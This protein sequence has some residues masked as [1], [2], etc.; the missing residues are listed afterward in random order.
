MAAQLDPCLSED[1]ADSADGL[2]DEDPASTV[3]EHQQLL[4]QAV[5]AGRVAA[6][7]CGLL[8]HIVPVQLLGG[9]ANRSLLFR[10]V[11][12]SSVLPV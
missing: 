3:N 4:Q 8:Q 11:R 7:V 9:K 6:F 2:P 12:T 1:E 5:P 10:K